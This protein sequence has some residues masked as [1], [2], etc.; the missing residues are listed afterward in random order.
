M[1]RGWLHINRTGY[2]L[3]N[4]LV[5]LNFLGDTETVPFFLAATPVMPIFLGATKLIF[6]GLT[7]LSGIIE[8]VLKSKELSSK[9]P[10]SNARLL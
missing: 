5:V 9:A 8:G 4:I 6:C 3:G 2:Y 10:T 1:K 7:V